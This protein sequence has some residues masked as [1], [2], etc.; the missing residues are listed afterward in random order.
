MKVHGQTSLD[1]DVLSQITFTVFTATYNRAHTL[2]RVY[3]SLKEQTYQQFEWLI[4]DDGSTDAT[5]TLV[6]NWQQEASFPIRYFYQEN[7]GKHVA[8][9]RAVQE[10]RGQY[11]VIIDSD[12][13]CFPWMLERFAYHWNTLS[14]QEHSFIHAIRGLAVNQNGKI[15]GTLFPYD[16]LFATHFELRYRFSVHGEKCASHRLDVLQKYPFPE[17][18]E[19]KFLPESII[20]CKIARHFKIK[21][22]NETLRIYYNEE[23]RSDRL[24]NLFD[25]S[26][27]AFGRSLSIL[28]L[29]NEG[30]HWF[31]CAPQ[32]FC[33][34]AANY[35]RLSLHSKVAIPVQFAKITN[36]FA[37]ILVITLL[38]VGIF[39]YLRDKY[40]HFRRNL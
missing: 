19:V 15:V 36:I 7:Q 4:V 30:I 16:N 33:V 2:H 34:K 18:E 10:A 35:S 12:D 8:I 24:C 6:Q 20:L 1:K 32:D 28:S 29:L 37:F 27:H 17:I 14:A 5:R 23:D 13:A 9:N 38:P 25:P 3:E 40:R 11:L 39:L 22:V 26:H 21:C 31:P